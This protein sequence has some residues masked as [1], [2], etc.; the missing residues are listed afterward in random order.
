MSNTRRKNKIITILPFIAVPILY[1]LV[2]IYRRYL[3]IYILPCPIHFMSGIYC[4]GCGGTRCVY[5]LMQL[6]FVRALRC[7]AL[8]CAGLLLFILYW[9][10]NAA[11]LLGKKIK[12]IPESRMFIITAS[13][14]AVAYVIARNF[15][16]FLAPI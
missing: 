8:V 16:P 14:I 4:A 7:N 10:E 11:A 2:Y 3:S 6:D 9:I 5:A 15:I 13:G 12:I 1:I